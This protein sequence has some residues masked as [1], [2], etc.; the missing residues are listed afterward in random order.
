MR[1]RRGL[2]FLFVGILLA[3]LSGVVILGMARQ[4]AQVTPAVVTQPEPVQK[5]YV[6]V[7]EKDIAENVALSAE[8]ITTKEFPAA[9]APAGAIA[10]PEY[11][12][13]KYTTSRVYKGQI[14]VAPLLAETRQASQLS[15]K[16]S[17][18]KI[19]LAVTFNDAM[20]TL[21]ALRAGDRVDIFITLD[22]AKGLSRKDTA[23]QQNQG[24]TQG[25]ATPTPQPSAAD[26]LPEVLQVSQIT[27]QNVEI[28]AVGAPAGDVVGD[29]TSQGSQTSSQSP[30][31][32]KTLTFLLDPQDAV[33]LK[34]LK[35]SGGVIDLGVRAP[36]DTLVSKTDAVSLDTIYQKYRFRFPQPLK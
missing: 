30:Q 33:I 13:G 35:D 26:L 5:V 11:A 34:F 28:L 10:A 19:G 21:G 16:V 27:M 2:I 7:A 17:D 32:N 22:L 18:G 14:L 6:V 1:K 20:N 25:A 8:D 31:N 4:A 23:T 24:T 9:F 12:V 3:V 29:A 36:N 15:Q